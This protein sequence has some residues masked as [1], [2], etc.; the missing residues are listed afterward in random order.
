MSFMFRVCVLTVV[1]FFSVFVL[2][3]LDSSQANWI[4]Q[5][6]GPVEALSALLYLLAAGYLLWARPI[7]W[8]TGWPA[9]FALLHLAVREAGLRSALLGGKGTEL[10]YY[11]DPAVVWPLKIVALLVL[12][13]TLCTVLLL[14]RAVPALL[15]AFFHGD[16]AAWWLALAFAYGAF[17]QVFDNWHKLF[18]SGYFAWQSWFLPLE[19]FGELGMALALCFAVITWCSAPRTFSSETEARL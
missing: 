12:G 11:L 9:A 8:G 18:G 7:S 13:A 2:T 3:R 1:L 19:E 4:L 5:E 10:A 14:L 15:R 17:A 16:A 6:H